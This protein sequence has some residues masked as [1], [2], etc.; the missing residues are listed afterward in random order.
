MRHIFFY[1]LWGES[2]MFVTKKITKKTI[3]IVTII[4]AVLCFA[5]LRLTVCSASV[6]TTAECEI[7]EYSLQ[8]ATNEERIKFL[9]QFGWEVEEEPCEISNVTIPQ[10]FN[11]TYSRYN[12]IQMEQGLNLLNYTGCECKRVSYRI[13]NY[14][15]P[16]QQVNANLLIYNG[17]VIGGDVSSVRLDGFMHGFCN[18]ED[19]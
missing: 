13:T 18:E 2:E 8:A 16:E 12:E 5:A 9:S 4:A 10:M 14:P 11:K 3:V 17:C 19:E 15:D 7:G 6:Q 1:M